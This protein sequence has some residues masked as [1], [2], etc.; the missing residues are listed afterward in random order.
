MSAS[1]DNTTNTLP[2][3]TG[4]KAND[5]PPLL[6]ERPPRVLIAG[7]GLGGLFLGILLE[8]ARI[9]F[10]IFERSAEIRPLGSIMCLSANILPAF[11]QLGL[12]EELMSFSKP[13][14]GVTFL[15]DRLDLIGK[16]EGTPAELVGY[17]RLLCA[18]PELYDML[19]KRI[20]PG[21]I[22]LSKRVL[23]F[24]QNHEGVKVH[25]SDN[26]SMHGDILVGAD[27]AH[28]AVRQHL[29]KTLTKE[30]LLPKTDTLEMSKG[31][32]SLLGTTES[33]DPAK[34]PEVLN[35]KDYFV[36]GDKD[37]P[38]TWTM[39]TIPGN[40]ICWN[41]VVQLGITEI[42]DE[43]FSCSDWVP[44]QNQK[45]MDSIRHFVTPHGALG[46][47]FDATPI[48]CVSK[49]YFEDMLFETW[50]H[51]R[52]VLI[53]DAAHK[54]LP[55][56]GAGAVNAMQDAVLLANH[57]YDIKPTSFDNIK[58]ALSDYKN[59]RFEA[60]K[61][62]YPQSHISAKLIFGH[63][64]LERIIRYVVFNWLPKWLQHRQLLKD[65]AYR[66]QAN[67]LPQAPKRGTMDAIPQN[68]SKSTQG[69]KEEEE[70]KKKAAVSAI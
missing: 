36:I 21:K 19:L 24:E 3:S 62:Q 57:I 4:S 9:P 5:L 39:F 33:L 44:Q 27:G 30:G 66:P 22:H 10:E 40:R 32:I 8:K 16:N 17:D 54:L 31:Y 28:S 14:Q 13:S 15:T 69:E 61:D 18:R 29:Y 26:T 25:F 6:T 65:T 2:P 64:L 23:S 42:A 47:L 68:P 46:D 70:T 59:E 34:F 51:G 49:V 63:T 56:S 11:E 67:F 60:I 50:N 1:F 7:A 58:T 53:G 41:V 20:P 55:S 43:Q 12:L 35:A 52:A 38:Y 48:E 37:T 45:M